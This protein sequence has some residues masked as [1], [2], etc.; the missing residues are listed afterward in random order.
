MHCTN[1][2]PQSN[3]PG[4]PQGDMCYSSR[5]VREYSRTRICGS[6][7]TPFLSYTTPSPPIS[8]PFRNHHPAPLSPLL[9]RTPPHPTSVAPQLTGATL[10]RPSR[11]FPLIDSR[12]TCMISDYAEGA[13]SPMPLLPYPAV[14]E[15]EID[16]RTTCQRPVTKSAIVSP[17]ASRHYVLRARFCVSRTERFVGRR[18]LCFVKPLCVPTPR[19]SP[20]PP[21]TAAAVSVS[22]TYQVLSHASMTT[23]VRH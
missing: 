12:I 6:G 13:R 21:I 17:C 7:F 9:P 3:P 23:R 2:F 18:F 8:N 11:Q 10:I 20:S 19:A 16:L 14:G 5:N 15:T 4:I 1:G 22:T